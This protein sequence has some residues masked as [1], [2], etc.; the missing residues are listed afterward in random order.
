MLL[1]ATPFVLLQNFLQDAIGRF[2]D[3][4]RYHY[5]A[6]DHFERAIQYDPNNK[7]T[8]ENIRKIKDALGKIK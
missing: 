5:C 2:T 8:R 1:V 3:S 4:G 6:L 7:F